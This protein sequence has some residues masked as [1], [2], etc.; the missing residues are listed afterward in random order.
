MSHKL[1]AVTILRLGSGLGSGL[2]LEF[3][4]GLNS[5]VENSS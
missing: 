5:N 2:R 3:Q 4:L 1:E